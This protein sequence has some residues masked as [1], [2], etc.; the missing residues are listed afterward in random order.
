MSEH[1]NE[2]PRIVHGVLMQVLGRGVLFLGR[3]GVGKSELALDLIDRGHHLIADDSVELHGET[4]H[5][6]GKAPELTRGT[7]YVRGVGLIEISRLFGEH[8]VADESRIDIC[9][10]LGCEVEADGELFAKPSNIDLLGIDV[11][12]VR[13]AAGQRFPTPVL[14]EVI[15]R[16]AGDS[17]CQEAASRMIARHKEML[18]A[19]N[20]YKARP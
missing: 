3:S 4:G 6:V 20:P 16:S 13:L 19:G 11:P 12:L 14:I 8:A 5:I 7:M 15:V 18:A 9:V 2:N 10:E 1:L 17:R